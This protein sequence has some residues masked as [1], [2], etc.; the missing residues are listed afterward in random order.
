MIHLALVLLASAVSQEPPTI[1][2]TEY[3]RDFAKAVRAC[4]TAEKISKTDP[5]QAL[6][7]LE[8]QVLPTLPR[9]VET[10]LV[11]K[12]SKGATK[13][14]EKERH[15]FFPWRL[16]GE[17]ALAT[18]RPDRAVEFLKK[19]PSFP[20]L[21]AKAK[22]ALAEKEKKPAP[23]TPPDP[24]P[25]FSVAP[26][27]EKRDFIGALDALRQEREKLGKEYEPMA[28]QVRAD[29]ARHARSAAAAVAAALPR[30]NEPE[31]P[32]EHLDPCIASCARVP[33]ESETDELR[34]I[35][36][37]SQWIQRRDPAEFD[38]L[39]IAAAKLDNDYHIVCEQAQKARLSEIEKWV[40]EARRAARADRQPLLERLDAAERAFLEVS[41]AKEYRDLS[42][43]LARAKARLPVNS[44]VL[45]EARK[46]V[47]TVAKARVLASQLDLLWTSE[48]RARLGDQD[49]KDL[50]VYLGLYRC[51]ALFLDG[52]SVD[53]CAADPRVRE[54]FA[55]A[56]PL[57]KDAPP[58]IAA[59]RTRLAERK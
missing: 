47:S 29:A 26:F 56:P 13:G 10:T 23:P 3:D 35:R 52:K 4:E 18:D 49:Q 55:A 37:L 39:A 30:L 59:L 8:E 21:L 48:D 25:A 31:F 41:R 17:C 22:S 20:T 40:D 34:W 12:F 19:S 54:V 6:R 58:K 9:L 38:R 14:A 51:T 44:D 42:A 53:E 28:A 11:V 36:R 5:A 43:A 24:K 33:A 45:D 2:E 50:A 57:P 15:E 27:L 1:E 7:T 46:G 16:A 32:R